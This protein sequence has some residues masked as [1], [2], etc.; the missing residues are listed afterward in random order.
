MLPVAGRPMIE[1]VVSHLGRHGVDQVILSLGYQPDAFLSAYP[2]GRCA[3]VQ[4]G[5]AVEPEP[6]DTA[7]AIAFAAR[8]AGVDETFLV[9]NGDVITSLDIDELVDFHR[10]RRA[11][12][13][14]SLTP[15]ED[16]SRYG[17]VAF[18]PDGRVTAFIEKPPPGTAPTNLINAGT[19]VLEP[20]ML[21]SIGDGE[22]VSIERSTFPQLVA[23]GSLYALASQAEWTD[24]G[25]VE[26][27]LG[28][29]LELAR[30]HD[31]WVDVMA[32]VDSS[33][34]VTESI[35][36]R[37]A[38]VGPGA[39]V[40]RALVMAGAQV[41]PGATVRDS[42][43][44]ARAVVGEGATIEA[45]SVLGPGMAVA[46]GTVAIGARFPEEPR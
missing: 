43:V 10:S 24:A 42:I 45:Y 6:L 12:A 15:V 17:V 29:N 8:H 40:E 25:T 2:D 28:I 37:G 32:D 34:K 36:G 16:P 18:D 1:W 27:Y 7:G 33:A 3:G 21:E 22:R 9:Q 4:I 23:A 31:T 35:I 26:T 30:R 13:T 14:I 19:Y 5:Y 39:L 46:A 38:R 44:G 20:P 11:S 41:G